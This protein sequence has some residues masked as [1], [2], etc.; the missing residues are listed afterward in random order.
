MPSSDPKS[1]DHYDAVTRAAMPDDFVTRLFLLRHGAV[2]GMAAR[3]VRGQ[4]DVRL[5]AH[6]HAQHAAL[7]EWLRGRLADSARPLRIVT[8]DLSRCAELAALLHRELG[9]RRN[10]SLVV[11][12]Q[13]REQHMGTWQG[14]TWEAINAREGKAINDYWDDYWNAAPPDGESM[15]TMAA[16]VEA[17]W[18]SAQ[19]D[20]RGS[21]VVLVTHAG[22][23][24]VLLAKWLG[25]P[26]DQSLRLAPPPATASVVAHS[27]AGFVLEGLGLGQAIAA[28]ARIADSATQSN[29]P[30]RIALSGSAGTGKTTLGRA[31][32]S[33]LGLPFI[34][35]RMRLR[36]E[37]GL[38]LGAM[39]HKQ[40][41]ALHRELWAEQSALEASYP[42]GFV[43]DR[44]SLDYA[45]FRLQYGFFDEGLGTDAFFETAIAHAQTY[46]HIL[47]FPHGAL[48]LVVDGV[49]APN[50]WLQLRFQLCVEGLL[51]RHVPHLHRVPR[52][53]AFDERF[54]WARR[55][56]KG[57]QSAD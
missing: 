38:R 33:E 31:L 47:L 20:L 3:E 42:D 55:I 32:A 4:R 7:V 13:L 52:T 25:L 21:D 48:P 39:T 45:A 26:G 34:E 57:P 41:E 17:W 14:Q 43:A 10:M 24:R 56:L 44:S 15:A 51:E 30:L 50:P 6:G 22:V 28:D 16:R 19:P 35:E 2:E 40:L 5:S 46:S 1:N 37:A 8:S 18:H 49:R 27:A 29:A 36:L 9:A 54:A 12:A 23:I 53:D 11:D